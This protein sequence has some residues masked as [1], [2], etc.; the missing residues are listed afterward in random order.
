[1]KCNFRLFQIDNETSVMSIETISKLVPL[2]D[3]YKPDERDREDV[4]ETEMAEED[5]FLKAVM[6]TNEMRSAYE[7]L[8]SKG[9]NTSGTNLLGGYDDRPFLF[10]PQVSVD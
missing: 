9:D 2:F 3:N 7:L 1:M 5:E 8:H 6:N 10:A 4:T